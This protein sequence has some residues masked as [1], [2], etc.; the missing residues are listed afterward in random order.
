[1]SCRFTLPAMKSIAPATNPNTKNSFHLALQ[2][3]D[4]GQASLETVSLSGTMDITHRADALTRLSARELEVLS[5]MAEGLRSAEIGEALFISTNTV[6]AHRKSIM[7]K[8]G[9]ANGVGAIVRG[10]REGLI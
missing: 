10:L 5:K 7:R 9:V 1:M 2:V 6:R 3:T 8:M 4:K